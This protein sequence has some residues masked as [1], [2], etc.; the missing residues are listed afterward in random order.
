MDRGLSLNFGRSPSLQDYDVTASRPTLIESQGDRGLFFCSFGVE[1]AYLQGDTYEQL[2][3]G[4]AQ[5]ES[6]DVKAQHAQVLGDRI[7]SL[8]HQLLSVGV[9]HKKRP[10]L[11]ADTTQFETSDDI[12]AMDMIE[13]VGLVLQSHLAL[14]YRAIPSTRGDSPLHFCDE[15]VT[16]SRAAIEGYNVAWEKYR[17]REDSAWKTVINW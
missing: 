9:S 16:A 7:I 13:G 14:A 8:R 1:L 17:T 2:Y 15:C 11:F 6:A 3:S 12:L 10:E 5:S 4:R